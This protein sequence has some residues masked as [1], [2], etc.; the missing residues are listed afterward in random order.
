MSKIDTNPIFQPKRV[1]VMRCPNCKH[2]FQYCEL[3]TGYLCKCGANL[4]ILQNIKG[5]THIIVKRIERQFDRKLPGL[6][7]FPKDY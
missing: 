5:E 3:D 1:M 7:D 2:D 4:A 6:N